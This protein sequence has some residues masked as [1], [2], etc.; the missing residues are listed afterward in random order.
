MTKWFEEQESRITTE[1]FCNVDPSTVV[2]DEAFNAFMEEIGI[3]WPTYWEMTASQIIRDA[4]R[5][6]ETFL[7]D[8]ANHVLQSTGAR[9]KKYGTEDTW[10]KDDREKFYRRILDLEIKNDE[11]EAFHWIRNKLTHIDALHSNEGKAELEKHKEVL[12]LNASLSAEEEALGLFHDDASTFLGTQLKFTP[13][14]TWRMLTI[15]RKHVNS[16]APALCKL[17]WNEHVGTTGLDNIR[18]D[19]SVGSLDKL[20]VR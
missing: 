4:Y 18:N 5:L 8:S 19:T 13:I 3:L 20:I 2:G 16:L 11:L 15:L 17:R 7:F 10:F 14:H 6:Y 9:L 1:A 12:G